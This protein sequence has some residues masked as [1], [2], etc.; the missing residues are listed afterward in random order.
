[1]TDWK[2]VTF[3]TIPLFYALIERE[4]LLGQRRISTRV[5]ASFLST[6]APVLV[7]RHRDELLTFLTYQY[8]SVELYPLDSSESSDPIA[9]DGLLR[10]ST[11]LPRTII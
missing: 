9:G 7:V 6:F 5:Y 1:M 2:M 11:P 3:D 10:G 4:I 8:N